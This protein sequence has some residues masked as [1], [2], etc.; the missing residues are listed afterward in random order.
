MPKKYIITLT[1]VGVII[2]LVH[3]NPRVIVKHMQ[4]MLQKHTINRLGQ[5]FKITLMQDNLEPETSLI[6]SAV[7][8]CLD[9]GKIL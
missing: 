1:K 6:T 9:E 8:I 4:T 5:H 7:V 2:Y 3:R